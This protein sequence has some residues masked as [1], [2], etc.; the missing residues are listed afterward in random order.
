MLEGLTV[1]AMPRGVASW[2][3]H[4]PRLTSD[5]DIARMVEAKAALLALLDGARAYAE[6]GP[7]VRVDI[8]H[9]DA[10]S[11]DVI[12][13][14]LG[15]GEV[16]S[17]VGGVRVQEAVMPGLWRLHD[18]AAAHALEVGD[19]PAIVRDAANALSANLALPEA[20]PEGA[21]NV[22]PVLV[23]I[24]DAMARVRPGV[25]EREINLTLLP[26]T[27]VDL[28]VLAE[29]LGTGDLTILS[30]GYGNCRITACAARG[31]WRVSYFNS[32]DKMI[33]DV[34]EVGD[35]P[36]AALA[37]RE[38]VADAA[39]RLEQVIAAYWP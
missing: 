12:D 39:E 20:L 14:I 5:E 36:E 11:L 16:Q 9:L 25:K 18:G 13:Q 7:A 4:T 22:A 10:A 17:V 1:P 27:P 8:S 3:A 6:G 26:M 34:V 35:V 37:A 29:A 15:Q 32:D 19:I 31:V 2:R 28:N 21:M 33:L 30:R 23:E 38:D 24:A